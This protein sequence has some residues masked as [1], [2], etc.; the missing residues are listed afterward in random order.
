MNARSK[1]LSD[2]VVPTEGGGIKTSGL[3]EAFVGKASMQYDAA[4]DRLID[5][6]TGKRY[7]PHN[8]LWVPE[9]GQGQ[10]LTSG[11]QENV[12]LRNYTDALTNETLRNGL[13][14]IHI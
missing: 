4:T 13:S 5:T 2:I 12:G 1:D 3:S 10:S 9:D 14:L 11:W 6:A 8:A 7:M